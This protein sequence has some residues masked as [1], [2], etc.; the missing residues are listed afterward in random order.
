ME[1]CVYMHCDVVMICEMCFGGRFGLLDGGYE[2]EGG[3][4]I[5]RG[6]INLFELS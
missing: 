3:R 2:W 1:G 5:G 6:M 4:K